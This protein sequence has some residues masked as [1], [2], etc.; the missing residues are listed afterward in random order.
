MYSQYNAENKGNRCRH[1][2]RIRETSRAIAVWRIIMIQK[3][4]AFIGAAAMALGTAMPQAYAAESWRDAFITRIMKQMSSDTTHSEV[5][6]T[7]LD[8]N[9]IPECFIYRSGI[10][11]GISDGFTLKDNTITPI[12]VPGNIIGDCLSD[13]TVYQKDG[14]YIFV[15]REVPR[16]TAVVRLYKLE[17]DG[18][19]LTATRIN[20]EDVNPYSTVP[21]ADMHS[22]ELL[23]NGYPNRSKIQKFINSYDAV[24]SLTAVE[25]DSAVSVDGKVVN[26][27]GYNVNYSNYYKIRDVAMVL[28]ATSSRFDVGWD[29]A[30]GAITISTGDKYTIV[31][32]EL[33]KGT[34]S[35]TMDITDNTAPIYVDGREQDVKCYNIGGNNYFKIR[36][37]ADLVGFA[38]NWNEATQTVEIITE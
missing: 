29:S 3:S 14:R 25:S 4:V 8:K 33:E 18:A 34:I 22:N 15:G 27:S 6:L 9:G 12:N 2:F 16:Y 10:D 23:S 35:T 30:T 21:Y 20:K 36:D 28:R 1:L 17:Y 24:N 38:V 32:G 13:I 7:D 31:G 5:A 26:V 19:T 37:I 11:G